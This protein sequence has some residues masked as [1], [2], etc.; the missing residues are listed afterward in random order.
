MKDEYP[1]SMQDDIVDEL[2]CSKRER[3]DYDY[4]KYEK[5][6]SRVTPS[7]IATQDR[8]RISSDGNDRYR[9]SYDD[10]DEMYRRKNNCR[11]DDDDDSDEKTSYR[12]IS[13][14]D[15][16]FMSDE[17]VD[18]MLLPKSRRGI[19]DGDY[20]RTSNRMIPLVNH[21]GSNEGFDE[22]YCKMR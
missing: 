18:E 5:T 16:Y 3:G 10:I 12:P 15:R 4:D 9:L 1:V 6:S 11:D 14:K 7:T 21:R 19:E 17:V 2:Y 22:R 13:M 20:K 8:Y